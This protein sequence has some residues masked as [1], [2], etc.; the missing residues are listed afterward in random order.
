MASWIASSAWL[1]SSCSKVYWMVVEVMVHFALSEALSL[2]LMWP[3]IQ[4]YGILTNYKKTLISL[5]VLW[6]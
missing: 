4:Q 6:R 3:R 1:S 5:L 2:V